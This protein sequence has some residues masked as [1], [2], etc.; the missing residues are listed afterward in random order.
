MKE[1]D[2]RYTLHLIYHETRCSANT[3]VKSKK[4][5]DIAEAIIKNWI[6]IFGAPRI[7]LSYNVCEFNNELLHEVCKQ[8]NISMKPTAA[9]AP[10]SNGIIEQQCCTWKNDSKIN[11]G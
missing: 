7:I 11:I 4:I 1:I 8:L 2:K 9:E 3:V 6:V 5:E 10:W